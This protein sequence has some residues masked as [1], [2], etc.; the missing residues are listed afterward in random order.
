MF[1]FWQWL[2]L[3]SFRVPPY[4]EGSLTQSGC[5]CPKIT[6][7]KPKHCYPA[8]PKRPRTARKKTQY[9]RRKWRKW[10]REAVKMEEAYELVEWNRGIESIEHTSDDAIDGRANGGSTEDSQSNNCCIG[11]E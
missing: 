1:A 6:I 5:V 11:E 4:H 7:V 3:Q 10:H 9:V 2:T 8:L